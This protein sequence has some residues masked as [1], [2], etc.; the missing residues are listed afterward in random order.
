MEDFRGVLLV[1][2][3]T[4][5]V[6]WLIWR[7]RAP[8]EQL[9]EVKRRALVKIMQLRR[10]A[11]DTQDAQRKAECW[12][13]AAQLA[14]EELN[15]PHLASRLAKRAHLVGDYRGYRIW[16]KSL[17][18]SRRYRDLEKLLWETLARQSAEDPHEYNKTLEELL[19]L[20]GKDGP[21]PAPERVAV[22]TALRK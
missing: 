2:V 21:L 15:R 8:K 19:Q 9:S 3:A 12:Q 5:F 7:L 6:V 1:F 16:A 20:Y 13:Q 10:Q 4:V 11:H 17:R 18:H 22:L 14:L